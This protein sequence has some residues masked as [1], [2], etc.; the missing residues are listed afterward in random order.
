MVPTTDGGYIILGSTSS[1]D[2]EVTG[3]HGV[4]DYWVVKI[5]DTGALQ[6]EKCLGGSM[7]DMG[8]SVIQ[9]LD[10][11]YIVAGGIES[12]DGDVTCGTVVEW[13][14]WV[15]KLSATGAIQW[16]N[17]YGGTNWNT[18]YSIKQTSDSNYVVL[19][20]TYSTDGQVTGNHGS[21][22]YWVIKISG[23]D[24]TL[25]WE[26]CYGGTSNDLAN[27]IVTTSDGGF[28]LAGASHSNNGNVSGHHGD[29]TTTDFWIVKLDDTGGVQWENS[30]GGT[31][32]DDAYSIQQTN[33]GGYVVAG[34][35]YS[36]NGQVTGHHGDST[37][38][39]IWVIKLDG[40]G[41]LQWQRSLGGSSDDLAYSVI[42]TWDTG[43]ALC[44]YTN[45]TD[46]DVTGLIGL[47]DYW[48]VKLDQTGDLQWQKPLG[49]RSNDMAHSIV[50]TPDSGYVVAGGSSSTDGEV[51][52]NHGLYDYWIVRLSPCV[53]DSA[54]IIVSGD[55]L[56]T[57]VSYNRY[58]WMHAGTPIA[59]ATNATFIMTD[60]GSYSVKVSDTNGCVGTSAVMFVPLSVPLIAEGV[61]NINIM[62]N[63]TSGVLNIENC[64]PDKVV[65]TD[66]IGQLKFEMVRPTFVSLQNLPAG[67]YIIK[68]L[69]TKGN[70]LFRS[71]VTKI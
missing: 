18:A 29:S 4:N 38:S 39:D 33:D 49:G 40:S 61:A 31:A 67:I 3:Q 42:Q 19:G 7:D 64:N 2:G 41:S 1:T 56:K 24:G 54:V 13:D 16:N 11:G 57:V 51:T 60:S 30:Y 47:N 32:T 23:V 34:S 65:I 14:Y 53:P 27:A 69:D 58:Q 63:P 20:T 66:A 12:S 21:G 28:A 15:V 35:S 70:M 6:W 55:T 68:L 44:G 50:E 22:D 9:T 17:C 52:G 25:I 59:G 46:D 10:G 43:Y 26:K 36:T 62:P 71:R 8:Y 5:D 48:I 45:S 37:T